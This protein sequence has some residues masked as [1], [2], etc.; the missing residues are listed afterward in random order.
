MPS[1]ASSGSGASSSGGGVGVGTVFAPLRLLAR[2]ASKMPI[3][4]ITLGF[5]IVTLAYFQLLHAVKH[6]EFLHHPSAAGGAGAAASSSDHLAGEDIAGGADPS[7]LA[8]EAGTLLARTATGSWVEVPAGHSSEA[9]TLVLHRVVAGVDLDHEAI[10][11]YHHQAAAQDDRNIL[12]FPAHSSSPVTLADEITPDSL[13]TSGKAPRA[14]LANSEQANAS[15]RDF[16]DYLRSSALSA[17][18]GSHQRRLTEVCYKPPTTS[19]F[20]ASECFTVSFD[21]TASVDGNSAL[22]S[23]GLLPTPEAQDWIQSLVAKQPVA[24]SDAR[25]YSYVSMSSLQ[26]RPVADSGLGLSFK[27]FPAGTSGLA[28]ASSMSGSY[29]EEETKSVRWMLYAA[30]AFV[31][32]FYALAKVRCETRA[33][34]RDLR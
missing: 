25:G 18:D 8:A 28:N 24:S 27:A 31:M 33:C 32:R 16:E 22:L 4:V 15:L 19:I 1:S 34:S 5:C 3:E 20:A 23:F 12:A 2:T 29:G 30:R 6:S 17:G 26:S 7:T 13:P 9:V 21:T 14:L 11:P 10:Y